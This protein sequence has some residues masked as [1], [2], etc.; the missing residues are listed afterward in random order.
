MEDKR[1][2]CCKQ[3]ENLEPKQ[4]GPDRVVKICKVCGRRHFEFSVDPGVI[5]AKWSPL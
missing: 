5:F 1:E 3:E 2:E 4:L